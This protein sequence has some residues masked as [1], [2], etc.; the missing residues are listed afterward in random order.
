VRRLLQISLG[1][2]LFLGCLQLHA[3]S[4]AEVLKDAPGV[5]LVRGHCSACH[6][7]QLVA[8]QR[9]DRQFW[10]KLIR[11]M[12]AEHNLWPLPADHEE[13]ILDYLAEHYADSDWGRRPPLPVELLPP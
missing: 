1:G 11:W 4:G 10:L 5:A 13:A 9:G 2:F 8:S 12:Q 6:S 7:L 3:Q